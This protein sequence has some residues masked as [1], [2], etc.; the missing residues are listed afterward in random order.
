MAHKLVLWCMRAVEI[1]FFTGVIG[2]AI[3]VMISW[4]SIFKAGFSKDDPP[5]GKS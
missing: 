4:V 3:V 5:S 2:C 1:I